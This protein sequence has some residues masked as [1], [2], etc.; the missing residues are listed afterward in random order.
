MAKW[1]KKNGQYTV[2]MTDDTPVVA[3]YWM[4]VEDK[5]QFTVLHSDWPGYKPLQRVA[6]FKKLV[7]AKKFVMLHIPKRS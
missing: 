4:I 6:K 7:D 5:K 2:K 3:R 1:E